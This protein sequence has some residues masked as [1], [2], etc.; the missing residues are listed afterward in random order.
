M[1]KFKE[2]ILRILQQ[3]SDDRAAKLSK[4]YLR[5]RPE[6]KEAI[7]AGIEIEKWFSEVCEVC[8]D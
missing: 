7:I 3:R 6:E 1:R 2:R 8:L 5:A 4:E